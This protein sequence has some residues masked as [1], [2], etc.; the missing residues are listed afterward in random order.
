MLHEALVKYGYGVTTIQ[1]ALTPEDRDKIVKEF[2]D[3]LTQVLIATDVLARG[4]DQFTVN[5]VV[6]Y[7]LPVI[8]KNPTEPDY[9]G[10][11]HCVGRAGL[12]G[13]VFNLLCGD[14]DNMIMEKVERHFNHY[15]TEYSNILIMLGSK[16]THLSRSEFGSD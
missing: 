1:G 16:K 10:Y 12:K 7:D 14:R 9:E 8:N 5:M 6:N 13:A 4:F 2:R 11:L 15:A 3:G